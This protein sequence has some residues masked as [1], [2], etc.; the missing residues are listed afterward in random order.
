MIEWFKTSP[1]CPICRKVLESAKRHFEAEV[2]NNDYLFTFISRSELMWIQFNESGMSSFLELNENER[3]RF[4]EHVA[5]ENRRARERAR[6]IAENFRVRMA[7]EMERPIQ[8]M[9]M[10]NQ[11]PSPFTR[12]S[13]RQQDVLEICYGT[14]IITLAI[15]VFFFQKEPWFKPATQPLKPSAV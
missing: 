9:R 4:L 14:A 15:Y 12:L 6:P 8:R 2:W 11:S 3:G 1:T 13:T 10:T 7:G 5:E